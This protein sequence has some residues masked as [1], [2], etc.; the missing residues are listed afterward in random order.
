MDDTSDTDQ[1]GDSFRRID[2]EICTRIAEELAALMPMN[3]ISTDADV[4]EEVIKSGYSNNWTHDGWS[5]KVWPEGTVACLRL[6]VT[7]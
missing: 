1:L 3:G 2:E 5:A 7:T 6:S 4:Y